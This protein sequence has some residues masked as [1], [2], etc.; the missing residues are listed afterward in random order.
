MHKLT[1]LTAAFAFLLAC[2]E[3]GDDAADTTGPGDTDGDTQPEESPDSDGD[4]LTDAEEA[5]AGT[6]PEVEDT[7]GDRLMDGDEPANGTDPTAYDTDGD[8]YA[9]GDE[10][11]EGTDPTDADS[12]IYE[13]GWP[14][15]WDKDSIEEGSFSSTAGEGDEVPRFVAVDQYG[16]EVDLYDYAYTGKP[17]MVD[18]SAVWCGPCNQMSNWLSHGEDWGSGWDDLRD[19]L[20]NGDFYWVTILFQ[21]GSGAASD[22][23]DVATWDESYPNEHVMVVTDPGSKMTA[24]INPPGIPSLSLIGEDMTWLVVDDT[25]TAAN[26]VLR[27]Y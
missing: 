8:G 17:I 20:D 25:V 10:V 16:E 12:K 11:T 14:Y 24:H 1:V 22:E 23:R 2:E 9:D 3:A 27:D 19:K 18:V 21:D 13:G 5:D 6:D 7:D 26:T 4:G 15:F